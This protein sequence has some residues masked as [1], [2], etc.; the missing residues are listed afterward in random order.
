MEQRLIGRGSPFELENTA[1]GRLQFRS[2]PHT[3]VQVLLALARR[4]ERIFLV[5]DD[6]GLQGSAF[7]ELALRGAAVL[8]QRGIAPG[9]RVVMTG[10]DPLAW[11]LAIA[12]AI[13]CGC[14]P[15]LSAPE[16][17][18]ELCRGYGVTRRVDVEELMS[19]AAASA[20]LPLSEIY[21][22]ASGDAAMVAFTSG[23]SGKP[24]GVRLDHAC[25]VSGLKNMML[26]AALASMRSPKRPMDDRDRRAPTALVMAPSSHTAGYGQLL[27]MAMI[28]G[29]IVLPR[30]W[31]PDQVA[32]II[33]R[34]KVN[35]L[36]GL[37]PPMMEDL[38]AIGDRTPTFGAG[39][40]N[41]T[42]FGEACRP[43]LI[44]RLKRRFPRLETG[45]G[46][47]LTESNGSV[48]VASEHDLRTR[49][50]TSGKL[51]PAVS[52]RVVD[53]RGADV[54]PGDRGELWLKG[55][56]MAQGYLEDPQG[57]FADGWFRTNDFGWVDG[58]GFLYLEE[59]D[60]ELIW[61]GD[62]RISCLELER[63]ALAHR[64]TI[65]AAAFVGVNGRFPEPMLAVVTRSGA[66]TGADLSAGPLN[67]DQ[68]MA[69]RGVRVIEVDTIPRTRSGKV[70]R[71]SLAANFN[72]G[73]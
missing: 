33:E 72:N 47:G 63:A 45:A 64:S 44:A 7:V 34:E 41:L 10:S 20:P 58:D 15:F 69:Q 60:N 26:A 2:G 37:T 1:D 27:L 19:R 42:V 35:S 70:D 61:C 24:K 53:G 66:R 48:A 30:A 62:A 68:E 46:Y 43:E 4:K 52:W 55:P 29:R 67:L 57:A 5:A 8:R 51:S 18:E 21:P 28:G 3:L 36:V 71:R 73:S 13:L 49:P 38:L 59:R 9:D 11:S 39:L 22:A 6:A 31:S 65:D 23:T 14:I 12:S 54:A 32:E 40:R 16:R 25:V 56:M 50:G 17:Y